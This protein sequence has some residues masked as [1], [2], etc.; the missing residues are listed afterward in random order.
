MSKIRIKNHRHTGY[1]RAGITF[2]KGE[3]EL[4]LVSLN[5]SQLAAIK[6]DPVLELLE[7]AEG[8]AETGAASHSTTQGPM[9]A[10]SLGSPLKGKE[11]ELVI[12]DSVPKELHVWIQVI[13]TVEASGELTLGE[14]GKP[15]C[16]SL[17]I[18]LPE[19]KTVT[20]LEEHRDAA[21][22]A[23]QSIVGDGNDDGENGQ[24][25]SSLADAFALLDPANQDHFTKSNKPQIDA[26]E[27][28]LGRKV[29]A[30]ERDAAW[31]VY[32]AQ[33]EQGQA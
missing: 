8:T 12:P 18:T 24:E 30:D 7:S 19:G 22:Q 10:L 6:A 33:A 31:D 27:K 9:D 4:Q 28:L 20:P 11:F 5:Q 14:D 1:R 25:L 32:Q 2:D 3:N 13:E 26:L 21:W 17:T 15:T 16:E 29:A 23:Y